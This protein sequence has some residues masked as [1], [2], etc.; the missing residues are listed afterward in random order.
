M[1]HT[2]TLQLGTQVHASFL[3]QGMINLAHE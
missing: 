1:V 3:T 2:H